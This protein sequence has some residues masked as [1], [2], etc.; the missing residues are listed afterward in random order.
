MPLPPIARLQYA[1]TMGNDVRSFVKHFDYGTVTTNA[2]YIPPKREHERMPRRW[3]D[4]RGVRRLATAAV[5]MIVIALTAF[6]LV[7][8]RG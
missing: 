5:I 8:Q 4:R 1:S 2:R 7:H 6:M 3:R